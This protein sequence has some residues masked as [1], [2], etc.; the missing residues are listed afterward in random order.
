MKKLEI[1]TWAL[2]IICTFIPLKATAQ[3]N[4][5]ISAQSRQCLGCHRTVTPGIVSDWEN[6][7]MSR[8][9]PAKAA[10]KPDLQKRVSFQNL[11]QNLEDIVT[12]CAE[13]HTLR[14]EKHSDTFDH[15]GSKVHT[16]VTPDD[17]AVCHPLEQKE[18]S[19][20]IMSEAHGNLA[21]NPV[22]D[23]M[24]TATIGPVSFS[25]TELKQEKPDD[26]AH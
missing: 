13:C 23:A 16:V 14:P 20:N 10:E 15:A 11:P 2:T 1:V 17:C 9:T 24:I 22:Y 25:G 18:F 8:I 5:G 19:K 3:D 4:A 21:G 12:G 6:S 26:T 7:R